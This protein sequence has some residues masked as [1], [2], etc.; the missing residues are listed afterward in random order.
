MYIT[1]RLQKDDKKHAD[2]TWRVFLLSGE[3]A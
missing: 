2:E 1:L 3:W